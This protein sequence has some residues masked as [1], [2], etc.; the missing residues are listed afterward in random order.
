MDNVTD[1]LYQKNGL[2]VEIAKQIYR[3]F[4]CDLSYEAFTAFSSAS[5]QD[6]LATNGLHACTES[7]STTA[8]CSAWLKCSFHKNFAPLKI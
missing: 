2:L 1:A 4:A 8:F 3:L 6:V 5:S 7:V